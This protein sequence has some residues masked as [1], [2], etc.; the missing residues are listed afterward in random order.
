MT[1]A[2]RRLARAPRVRQFIKF[3]VVGGSGVLVDMAVLH[4]LACWCGWNVSLSKL[5]AAAVA[6]L[7]NFLWNELWTFRTAAREHREPAG[8]FGRLW[9]FYA[10]CGL[11]IG[12]AV[13]GLRFFHAG[14]G[15]NLYAANFLAILLVTLWN[16]GLNARF[17]WS[18]T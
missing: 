16:Y 9:R 4:G 15:F 11:G 17:N 18:A 8:V 5:C 1:G 7:N 2:I 3:C 10:I 13:L 14:L 12:L 6:M